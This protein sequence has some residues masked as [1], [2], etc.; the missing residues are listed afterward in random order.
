M[1]K[2]FFA[3]M[4]GI[5]SCAT[6]S[7]FAMLV[8]N[9]DEG[10]EITISRPITVIDEVNRTKTMGYETVVERRYPIDYNKTIPL[11]VFEAFA[12][13]GIYQQGN[14]V[15]TVNNIA[16][17]KEALD[18]YKENEFCKYYPEAQNYLEDFY[19]EKKLGKM[20]N[21]SEEHKSESLKLP[22][23]F[24]YVTTSSTP[25]Q[26]GVMSYVL[27]RFYEGI[28]TVIDRRSVDVKHEVIQ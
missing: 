1:K 24:R 4:V 17:A 27:T 26:K 7:V 9:E 28:S 13:T 3:L 20:G 16:A 2:R 22:L 18:F 6:S 23:T 14:D 12:T 8:E 21:T 15:W 11:P 19:H 25:Y 5:A 10:Y